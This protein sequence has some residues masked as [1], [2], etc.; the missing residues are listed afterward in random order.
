M[1][2]NRTYSTKFYPHP[3]AEV[4]LTA[5]SF[6]TKRTLEDGHKEAVHWMASKMGFFPWQYSE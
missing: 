4:C 5:H 3:H 2:V 1:L 6:W